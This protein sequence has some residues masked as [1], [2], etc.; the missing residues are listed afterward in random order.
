MP[1]LKYLSLSRTP[2]RTTSADPHPSS[3]PHLENAAFHP[4]SEDARNLSQG[5]VLERDGLAEEG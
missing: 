5:R 3:V 4:H 1:P 2:H